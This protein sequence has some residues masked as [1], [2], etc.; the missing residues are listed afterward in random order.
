VDREL[1]ATLHFE[2][3]LACGQFQAK[4]APSLASKRGALLHRQAN[5]SFTG[6]SLDLS[7]CPPGHVLL[8]LRYL[9]WVTHVATR[10]LYCVYCSGFFIAVTIKKASAR[11]ALVCLG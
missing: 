3:S 8:V 9:Y 6:V 11:E 7:L 5:F 4:A 2:I 10:E 1:S